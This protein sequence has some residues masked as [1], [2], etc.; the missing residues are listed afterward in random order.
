[1]RSCI[2]VT[3]GAALVA[4][5]CSWSDVKGEQFW[6]ANGGQATL[7][8]NH[9]PLR[10]LGIFVSEADAQASQEA[11][12]SVIQA[13]VLPQPTVTF[14]VVNRGVPELLG[15]TLRFDPGLRILCPSCEY[16][17]SEMT[18][19]DRETDSADAVGK[20]RALKLSEA[21][22]AD[23]PTL[24]LT[25]MKRGF[26]WRNAKLK[27]FS[28]AM[29]LSEPL[30]RELGDP[31][32]AGV[33]IGSVMLMLETH[34]ISGEQPE[35]PAPMQPEP[36]GSGEDGP[37]VT[38]CQLYQLIQ[39]GRLED[40][41]VEHRRRRGGLDRSSE[42]PSPVHRDEP[43]PA[44]GRPFRADRSVVDQARVL[45]PG[46]CAVRGYVYSDRVPLA[47]DRMHRYLFVSVE[48]IAKRAWPA[49]RGQSL[50]RRLGL[51][52]RG[53]ASGPGLP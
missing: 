44:E 52:G 45:R 41:F 43:V 31:A 11:S 49:L 34:W 18:L 51:L 53:V 21:R 20:E 5:L 2:A 15:R 39:F 46:Q 27:F 14:E 1:M 47:G 40:H 26:D 42:R 24:L 48:C 9:E 6:G 50:D 38:F 30:A 13:R 3:Y 7:M 23:G 19:V 29:I 4:S 10:E 12:F 32:L 36:A 25:E 22:R 28:Q 33:P 8:L 16:V 17:V 35:R 37:D